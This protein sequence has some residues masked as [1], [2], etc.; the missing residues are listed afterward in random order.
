MR[1]AFGQKPEGQ[2]MFLVTVNMPG[3]HPDHEG[4]AF[5][6]ER[7]ARAHINHEVQWHIKQGFRICDLPVWTLW[8][9]GSPEPIVESRCGVALISG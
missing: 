5:E 9:T 4:E 8:E 2:S 1:S 7:V 3:Y 6:C